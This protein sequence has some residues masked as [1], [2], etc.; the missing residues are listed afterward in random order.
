[1]TVASEHAVLDA[2]LSDIEPIEPWLRAHDGELVG[3][4]ESSFTTTRAALQRHDPSAREETVRL[5]AL[6][7]RAARPQAKA[8]SASV[9][10][11]SALVIVRE[12][13]E[14]AVIIAAL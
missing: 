11:L 4:L 5:L 12:G 9:F 8:T 14:A 10:G 1:D 2:Y 6:L 13:F 3:Q 7:D